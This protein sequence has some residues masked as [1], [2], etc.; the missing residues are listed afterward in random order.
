MF[1]RGYTLKN[2]NWLVV[3]TYPSEKFEF[4]SWDEMTISQYFLGKSFKI[5]WFQSPPSS[6][7]NQPIPVPIAVIKHGWKSVNPE[8]RPLNVS[9]NPESYR[10]YEV[11][12][13]LSYSTSA[14]IGLWEIHTLTIFD[15]IFLSGNSSS[16][17]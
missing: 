14:E 4:V 11:L 9:K 8:M 2:H 7:K 15:P 17:P 6:L 5:P 1:T 12:G 10:V 13:A 16:N 3:S